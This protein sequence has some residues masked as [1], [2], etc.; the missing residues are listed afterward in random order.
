MRTVALTGANSAAGR[1]VVRRAHAPA[2]KQ[3]ELVALVRSERAAAEVPPLPPG[4][5]LVQVGYDDRAGFAA[6]L[7]G[8]GALIHLPGVL[9]ERPGST[10]ERANVHAT[11]AALAAARSASVSRLVLVSANGADPNS[12]NRY[13]ATKGLAEERVRAAT[14][15]HAILR[16]PMLMGAGTQQAQVI[17]RALH[18]GRAWL[19]GGGATRQ[20]PLDVDDLAEAALRAASEPGAAADGA[21]LELGGPEALSTRELFARAARIAKTPIRLRSLP[22]A[23]LRAAL[24]LRTRLLGPGP[25]PDFIDV[26]T[27]DTHAAAAEAARA[28]GIELTPLDATIRKGMDAARS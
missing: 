24:A 17:A 2:W 4:G 28:L 25:S 22:A 8:A 18:S 15:A 5:R 23:P 3:I 12:T 11:E 19:I 10:Y 26:L 9:V 7:Q 13:F 21:T 16:A 1:A 27:T 20:E 14:T 6:A